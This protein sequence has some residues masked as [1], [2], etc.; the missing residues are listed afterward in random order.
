MPTPR[1]SQDERARTT[2]AALT[3]T[4]RRLFTERGYQNVPAEEIANAAGLTRGALYHHYDDKKDLFREVFEQLAVEMTAEVSVV[5][6]QAP[7]AWTGLLAALAASLDLADRPEVMQ[8]AL[9]D[10]PAVLGW[11]QWRMLEA[12]HGLGLMVAALARA[13]DDGVLIRTPVQPL[14]QLVLA[15]TTEA[16]LMIAHAEDRDSARADALQALR[17]LL[18]GVVNPPPPTE[19][20]R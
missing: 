17:A 10:A 20:G 13:M 12:R 2:R 19:R 16:G 1:R 8:I 7:D 15:M 18:A 5:A 4:A 6:R 9:T 11:E 14:A 3:A